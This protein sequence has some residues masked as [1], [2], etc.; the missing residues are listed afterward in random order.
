MDID[1]ERR[2]VNLPQLEQCLE[3]G[4]ATAG[5]RVGTAGLAVAAHSEGNRD[6]PR[7][8]RS[9]LEGGRR[10]REAARRLGPAPDPEAPPAPAGSPR[11]SRCEPFLEFIDLSLSKGRNA[12]GI[13]QNLV[14]DHGFTGSYSGVKRFVRKPR[15]GSNTE[16]RAVITT[17]PGE[18]GRVDYGTGPMVRDPHSGR[19]RRT[20]MFVLTLGYSRKAVRLQPP[21]IPGG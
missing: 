8:S 4:Q 16:T 5:H 20:R 14:D 11:A 9:L 7:N 2:V 10:A 21:A 17:P 18:D 1:P 6:P 3:R 15:G 12:K 19:Y 13:W